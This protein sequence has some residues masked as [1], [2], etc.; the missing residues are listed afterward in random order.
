VSIFLDAR[1]VVMLFFYS[2][3]ISVYGRDRIK[4]YALYTPSHERMMRDYFLPSIQDDFDII[5]VSYDQECSHGSYMEKGWNKTMLHKVELVIRAIKENWGNF[6]IHS[7]V[8]IQF[9]RPILPA[10]VQAIEGKDIVC[11]QE[12]PTGGLC[13][14]FFVC[15]GNENTLQLWNDIYIYLVSSKDNQKN[16][17][18]LLNEFLLSKYALTYQKNRYDVVWDY[19]PKTFMGGGITGSS[20]ISGKQPVISKDIIMY[21]ANYCIGVANKITQLNYIKKVV[22]EF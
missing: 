11:Q 16:D 22:S 18:T 12:R 14:G 9:F 10:I 19:L 20:W 6:F 3:V 1:R 2:F 7:D 13:A 15:R 5:L 17:Q 4:L 8:D 21:H